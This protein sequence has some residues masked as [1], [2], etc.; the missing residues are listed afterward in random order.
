MST[1]LPLTNCTHNSPHIFYPLH[2]DWEILWK[3]QNLCLYR[4]NF[5]LSTFMSTEK[6]WRAERHTRLLFGSLLNACCYCASSEEYFSHEG[7]QEVY[8]HETLP[9]QCYYMMI[10]RAKKNSPAF[11]PNGKVKEKTKGLIFHK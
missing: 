1:L 5:F 2:M 3:R 10:C 6:M 9:V 7:M 8:Q 11:S 4:Y